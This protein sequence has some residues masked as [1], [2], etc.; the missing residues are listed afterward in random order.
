MVVREKGL[1]KDVYFL[2]KQNQVQDFLN[3]ATC[4][5]TQ[6]NR[7]LWLAALEGMACG[8]PAVCSEVG[9]YPR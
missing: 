3:C 1:M 7:V 6:R 4:S 8:V 2:G 5:S 9:D